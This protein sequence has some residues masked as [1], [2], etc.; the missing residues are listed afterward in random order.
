MPWYNE[1]NSFH[2]NSDDWDNHSGQLFVEMADN[3]TRG[4]GQ[5]AYSETPDPIHT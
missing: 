2:V 4:T 5:R 1:Q 3:V